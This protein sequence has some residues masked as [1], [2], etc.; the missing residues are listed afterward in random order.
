MIR[1]L[2]ADVLADLPPK[3]RMRVPILPDT[4]HLRV[5][6][7]HRNSAFDKWCQAHRRMPCRQSAAYVCISCRMSHISGQVFLR[8]ISHCSL[9]SETQC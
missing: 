5:R 1:R 8:H 9:S 4:A 6:L 3:R 2:K 7:L